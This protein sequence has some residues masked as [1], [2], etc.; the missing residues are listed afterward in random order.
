MGASYVAVGAENDSNIL[1]LLCSLQLPGEN[2]LQHT[3][4]CVDFIVNYG[5]LRAKYTATYTAMR[6]FCGDLRG[7]AGTGLPEKGERRAKILRP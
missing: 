6:G 4:L 5:D 7:F 1:L 3:L 2:T